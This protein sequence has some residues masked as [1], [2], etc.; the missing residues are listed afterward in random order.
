MRSGYQSLV[1]TLYPKQ[2]THYLNI[3][4]AGWPGGLVLGSLVG[5]YLQSSGW[6]LPLLL[7]LV[8]VLVYGIITLM[9]KFP[10]SEAKRAGVSYGEMFSQFGSP[11]LLFLLFIH[12]CVGYVELGTDSWISNITGKIAT[13]QGAYCLFSHQP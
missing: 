9:E 2:K 13:G 10:E 3:L 6:Q 1:A 7:F 4:H 5:K 12:A 8:P 11:I